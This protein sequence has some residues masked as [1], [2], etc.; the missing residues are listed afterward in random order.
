MN[1]T[2]K[3]TRL[4]EPLREE[5]NQRLRNGEPAHIEAASI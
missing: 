3:I 4:P 5:L 2:S 1:R